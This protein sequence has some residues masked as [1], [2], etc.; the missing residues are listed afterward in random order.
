MFGLGDSIRLVLI[1]WGKVKVEEGNV[2]F[3]WMDIK[4]SNR[5]RKMYKIT[6]CN[7]DS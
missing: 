6:F 3:G 4:K 2:W 1:Y 5:K 7:F